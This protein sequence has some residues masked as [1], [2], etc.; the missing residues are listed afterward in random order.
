MISFEQD[1]E[2]VSALLRER[3]GQQYSI[4]AAY[5]IAAD[6]FRSPIR[7]TLGI[8]LS[9]RGHMRTLRSVLF[10]A[11]LQ[12]YLEKGISQ[13]EIE[14]PDLSA[15]L[16][17]Y[18]DG[19][20]VLMFTDDV[21]RDENTLRKMVAKAFGRSDLP[22][23]LITTGRWELSANIADRFASGKVFLAGDA[24]HTLP[25]TR[26]G[27]GANTGI[28]DAHNLAWKLASVLA[29]ESTPQLLD[30]YDVERRTIAWLRNRQLFARPDYSAEARPTD[31]DV[32]I[33]D[34]D[35]MEFGQLYRSIGVLG[36]GNE[37]PPA[38]RPDL[39][40][41]Q[42]GTRAPHAWIRIGDE[43]LSTLDLLQRTWVL[44][45]S[46][47]RWKRAALEVTEELGVEL[48]V[49]HIGA[50]A[51]LTDEEAF[52]SALG[53]ERGGAS[54]VRPDGYIAWR[55]IDYPEHPVQALMNALGQVASAVQR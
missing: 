47:E 41:G 16:T 32:P 36:A 45:A 25:P 6:G 27:Y 9:G 1:G 29:G 24:A 19:R 2:G 44:I 8:G 42:P 23:K 4:R 21:E 54:L 5:L 13:F 37:L 26:G 7:A 22:I 51:Q 40:K 12:E 31:P 33:I 3:D 53:L 46:D 14:Q 50:D 17:T 34:D 48:K 43:E 20:W 38:L 39:W 15:F 11:P 55:S 10:E 28:D 30:T 49:V 18:N 35:A 52:R